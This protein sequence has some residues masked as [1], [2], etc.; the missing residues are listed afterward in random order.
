MSDLVHIANSLVCPG[1]EFHPNRD[2]FDAKRSLR[3]FWTMLQDFGHQHCFYGCA[4]C[5]GSVSE[6]AKSEFSPGKKHNYQSSFETVHA[7]AGQLPGN[8]YQYLVSLAGGECP[9]CAVSCALKQFPAI[10]RHSEPSLFAQNSVPCF[11][12]YTRDETGWGS[13]VLVRHVDALWSLNIT[14]L[15]SR[16]TPSDEHEIRKLL[17]PGKAIVDFIQ[18][19]LTG[20]GKI[21][22]TMDDKT[23]WSILKWKPIANDPAV[24]ITA[25]WIAWAKKELLS[26]N[27]GWD[28]THNSICRILNVVTNFYSDLT[29]ISE[30]TPGYIEGRGIEFTRFL[31]IYNSAAYLSHSEIC[32]VR[33]FHNQIASLRPTFISLDTQVKSEPYYSLTVPGR[34]RAEQLGG[35]PP[36]FF[37]CEVRVKRNDPVLVAGAVN[38]KTIDTTITANPN[39]QAAALGGD[40]GKG[41][42]SDSVASVAIKKDVTI[43][44]DGIKQVQ[45]TNVAAPDLSPFAMAEQARQD[46][47]TKRLQLVLE[48][49]AGQTVNTPDETPSDD[50]PLP[51]LDSRV[52]R[53]DLA[54]KLG[55]GT[56]TLQGWEKKGQAPGGVFWPK[57]EVTP[58]NAYYNFREVWQSLLSLLPDMDRTQKASLIEGL[59]IMKRP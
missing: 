4:G 19:S 23:L 43:E 51:P 56:D 18:Q 5:E 28:G 59:S 49:L 9:V 25:A 54:A 50:D 15:P 3:H 34:L 20:N 10:A 58:N 17:E 14:E 46:G 2:S 22:A 38:A 37:Q 27:D 40:G 45:T 39:A 30:S 24:E 47:E 57:A 35:T 26:Q 55:K 31:E 42:D 48:R 1:I 41:G 7:S 13:D 21:P 16:L 12:G 8:I 6:E 33:D 52:S 11:L 44:K 53:A 29:T 32:E 36:P